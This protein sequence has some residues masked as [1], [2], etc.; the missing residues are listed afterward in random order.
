[1]IHYFQHVCVLHRINPEILVK[2]K[3]VFLFV[4]FAFG[5]LVSNAEVE[6][7]KISDYII[8]SSN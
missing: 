1:M 4:C 8:V 3:I 5:N 7:T 6:N 2:M